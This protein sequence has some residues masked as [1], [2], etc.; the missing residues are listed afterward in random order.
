MTIPR[1][2]LTSHPALS[3]WCILSGYCGSIAHGTWQPASEPSSV[4]DKDVM[5]VCVPP[6]DTYLGLHRFGSRGRPGR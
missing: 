3:G 1:D 2:I 5:A 6:L 4:D